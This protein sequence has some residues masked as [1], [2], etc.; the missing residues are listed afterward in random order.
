M[1]Y[2]GKSPV[3]G[4]YNSLDDI[5]GSF[6]SSTTT[7]NLLVNSG[8]ALTPVRAEALIISINGVIQE[9]TTDFT[10]SAAT[11]TFT[12][13]PAS[14]D[15]FFG[16][17]LG[18]Q[19]D[20]AVPSDGSVS[21]AKIADGA[22]TVVKLGETVTVAKGGTGAA[23]HTANGVLLGAGTGAITTAA[24]STSGNILTSN[25]TVWAS[26]VPKLVQIKSMS[27]TTQTSTTGTSY[28]ATGLTLAFAQVDA[29][30]YIW[31][32][33]TG[34]GGVGTSGG[35]TQARVHW[36]LFKDASEIAKTS[37][38]FIMEHTP[39]DDWSNAGWN[40]TVGYYGSQ[41]DTT[42]YT[43]TLQLKMQGAGTDTT[44]YFGYFMSGAST[45]T[46]TIL[47]FAA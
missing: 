30:N 2:I 15:S 35:T 38:N 19:L 40:T 14:T 20:I 31:I 9:P 36:A 47:E 11:I 37:G 4:N 5:S 8:T 46:I 22:V 29:G 1:P 45:S 39:G 23:T 7:F 25:G 43:Y 41:G 33:A 42:S 24:P 32:N 34:P 44:G 16:V 17:V 6:N 18:Q 12:T 10:V 3:T 27:T 26:A 21:T 28:V 13:A